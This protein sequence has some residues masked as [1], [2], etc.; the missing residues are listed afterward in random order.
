MAIHR[1]SC[2]CRY[3]NAAAPGYRLHKLGVVEEPDQW[4][5][6]QDRPDQYKV[7]PMLGLEGEELSRYTQRSH[8]LTSSDILKNRA[9]D[10]TLLPVTMA[11]VPQLRMTRRISGEYELDEREVHTR[12]EDSIGMVSDWRKRG[13]VFE[14]PV[15]TLYSAK[16]KNLMAAG[17]C[18]SVTDDMWDIMRVIPCCAVTG[19]AAGTAAAM[20]DDFTAL[21]VAELQRV[22]QADGVVLHESELP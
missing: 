8:Q 21:D 2:G 16:V 20:T 13:P 17:R 12:F 14:V 9:E 5:A 4:E 18:T 11:T 6:M 15:R 22:L 19:Q 10:P 7:S 3:P 1:S